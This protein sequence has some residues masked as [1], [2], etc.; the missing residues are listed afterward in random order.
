M[1][2]VNPGIRWVDLETDRG[3]RATWGRSPTDSMDQGSPGPSF[4][5]DSMTTSSSSGADGALQ[6]PLSSDSG[7][8]QLGSSSSAQQPVT[9]SV[10]HRAGA[11]ANRSGDW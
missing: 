11:I 1:Q 2:N 7:S 3:S 5:E 4:V 8:Q 6:A 10:T 9:V